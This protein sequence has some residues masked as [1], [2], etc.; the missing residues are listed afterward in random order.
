MLLSYRRF[1][2]KERVAIVKLTD[3]YDIFDADTNEQIG[4]AID[5]PPAWAKFARLVVHKRFLP[6]RLN[7]YEDT[8]DGPVFSLLKKPGFLRVELTVTDA[9]GQS[10]GMLRSKI[11][12]LGGGFV[13]YDAGGSEVAQ[14]NGDWKGW[15]F[16]FVSQTGRELGQVTKKWVGLGKE[17]FT[18]ADNYVITLDDSD[19]SQPDPKRAALLL[20]A[21]LSID[22]VFKEK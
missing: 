16:R 12:K 21:G 15:T 7:V 11:F 4:V 14:V 19:D 17:F 6:T 1:L 2:V 20:A 22:T 9:R 10:F 18:S 5:E 13:V 8:A 3:T